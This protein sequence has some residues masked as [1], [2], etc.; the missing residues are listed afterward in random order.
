MIT[1]IA[2]L[3]SIGSC[4]QDN[5][6]VSYPYTIRLTDAPASVYQ[7][8]N[9]DVQ[10]I[11]ITGTSMVTTPEEVH[12]GVYN[13]LNYS[14]G[15]SV[16]ISSGSVEDGKIQQIRLILGTNNSVK[17]NG[18]KIPLSTPSADQSGLKLQINA[19]LR[20]G[21]QYGLMLDFDAYQSVVALGNGQY[22]LKP[23]IRVYTA[24]TGGT[25]RGTTDPE[26]AG[27][28]VTVSSTSGVPYTTTVSNSGAFMIQGLPVGT[29]DLTILSGSKTGSKSDIAVTTGYV[30][31]VGKITLQ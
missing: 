5:A 19:T 12:P 31:D 26:F 9:I 28:Q 22:K 3:F 2:L 30:T 4:Q 29:Y 27:S 20:A 23:V 6:P 25:I 1:V 14:N 13:L 17:I 11:E 16:L 21:I 10:G 24:A 8:V 15:E 18:E 7:E